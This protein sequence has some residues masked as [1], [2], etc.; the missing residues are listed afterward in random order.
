MKVILFDF[1]K[2]FWPHRPLNIGQEA[3]CIRPLL[4]I[5]KLQSQPFPSAV[6][7][8]LSGRLLC[9]SA[10]ILA[11][12]PFPSI[13]LLLG[14]GSSVF[15]YLYSSDRGVYVS[16]RPSRSLDVIFRSPLYK[17]NNNRLYFERVKTLNS[18]PMTLMTLCPSKQ[19]QNIDATTNYYKIY[20]I[21]KIKY[22]K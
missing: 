19:R 18:S 20:H 3:K 8:L 6:H 21:K 15:L 5:I 14:V 16:R 10:A 17:N 1:E 13:L 2:S 22:N 11:S 9:W 4:G 7:R 12:Y